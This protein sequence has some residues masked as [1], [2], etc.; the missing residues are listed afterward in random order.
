[1]TG[2]IL[3]RIKAKFS[4]IVEGFVEHRLSLFPDKPAYQIYV[5]CYTN[6]HINRS[7]KRFEMKKACLLFDGKDLNKGGSF[8]VWLGQFETR[9]PCSFYDSEVSNNGNIVPSSVETN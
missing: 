7:F 8:L 2:F 5:G 4:L 1:M 6:S 9:K 3:S